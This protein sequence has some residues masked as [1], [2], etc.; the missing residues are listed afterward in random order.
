MGPG[1]LQ[2]SKSGGFAC[3]L[4]KATHTHTQEEE[5]RFLCTFY[6]LSLKISSAVLKLQTVCIV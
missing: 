2:T 1:T 3:F 5:I 4:V 6:I